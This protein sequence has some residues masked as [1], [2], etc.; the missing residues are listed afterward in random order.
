VAR[1]HGEDPR[2]N[3]RSHV[4]ISPAAESDLAAAF[5]WYERAQTGLGEQFLAEVGVQSEFISS[6]PEAYPPVHQKMRRT[7]RLPSSGVSTAAGA[8]RCGVAGREEAG[9]I[10]NVWCRPPSSAA[11]P[12]ILWAD[13]GSSDH[14][15]NR[16]TRMKPGSEHRA[17]WCPRISTGK[18]GR[19]LTCRQ[20][21][22]TVVPF[23]PEPRQS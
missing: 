20:A 14:S 7:T 18:V 1:S 11:D 8:R 13:D 10:T 16:E 9:G 4:R 22:T 23:N 12:A 2:Q 15:R 3:L 6:N 21:A 19:T 5:A 17:Q